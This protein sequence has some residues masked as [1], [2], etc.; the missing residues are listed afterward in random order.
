MA[1]PA[2]AGPWEEPG[3]RRGGCPVPLS[4][5][6]RFQPAADGGETRLVHLGRDQLGELTLLAGRGVEAGAPVPEGPVAVGHRL[7]IDFGHIVVERD[8]GIDDGVAETAIPVRQRKQSLANIAAVPEIEIAHAADLV[9][10]HR[11]L[12]HAAPND[13]VPAVVAVEVA[14]DLPYLGDRSV[15]HRAAGDPDHQDP[16][17]SFRESNA[18]WKTPLPIAATSSASA[19]GSQSNSAVHSAKLRPPS[20]TGT[21]LRVAT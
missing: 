7:Q 1:V 17:R 2:M 4:G 3:H 13:G 10:A 19:A 5:G 15:D 20:V 16:K 21:S 12:Q 18:A 9:G 6:R 14:Q 8:I 11:I